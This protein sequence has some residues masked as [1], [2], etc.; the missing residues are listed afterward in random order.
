MS[1]RASPAAR[2]VAFA[3][4]AAFAT[5]HW[6]GLVEP[7][8]GARLAL[9]V[10][11]V[12]A[13][14]MAL[15][16][17]GR[18][19]LGRLASRLLAA[20]CGT[21]TLAL[22]L[23]AIGIGPRLLWPGGWGEL[24]AGLDAG[25]AGLSGDV[26]YPYR[27]GE[28][29]S[30]L[31]ILAVAPAT[32]SAAAMLAFS[33]ALERRRR[34]FDLAALTLLVA[35]Y[36]TA[37][38]VTSPGGALARGAILLVLVGAWLW[39][40]ALRWP[41]ALL[42]TGLIAAAAALAV[43]AA[44]QLRADPWLDYRQWTL[45]AAAGTTYSWGHSYGPID[46][47]RDGTQMLAVR[48]EEAHYWKTVVLDR[49][50]GV[51]WTRG[52]RSSQ[53]VRDI[54]GTAP[55]VIGA[56]LDPR[57][58]KEFT[59]MIADL[60]SEV[61]VAAGTPTRILG[62]GDVARAPDG[63][64]L[65]VG[66]PLRKGD[67]YMVRSYI[68]DPT[69]EQMRAAPRS[70]PSELA[71]YTRIELPSRPSGEAVSAATQ[72]VAAPARGTTL[73]G[74]GM[75]AGPAAKRISRSPYA[76][77]LGL[78]RELT[79]GKPTAYDAVRAVQDHLRNEYEYSEAPPW[80]RYPL[81]AFLTRDRRGY[82]QQFSGTMALMLRMAGIPSRVASGFAP[83]SRSEGDGDFRVED[84]DAHAWVEVYF[85]GIGWV[86][87]DPTPS[88]APVSTQQVPGLPTS[89]V[90]R[91][92]GAP[93][94]AGS[95]ELPTF[96]TPAVGGAGGTT[97]IVPLLAA[98][99]ALL[100]ALLGVAATIAV[101]SRRYRRLSPAHAAEAQLDELARAL[102]HLGWSTSDGT[103]L[104]EVGR[105]LRRSRRRAAAGYVDRVRALRYAGAGGNPPT[106]AERRTLRRDLA[107]GTG[108]RGRLRALAAI[109]PGAPRAPAGWRSRV[110]A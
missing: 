64:T 67:A 98:P 57:W 10:A 19:R 52:D 16:T 72:A 8:P 47:P 60:E 5:A 79:E 6:A 32:L 110:L 104:L 73:S 1:R 82:C 108:A 48:S 78:T 59:V 28:E 55:E 33:P 49:F 29:W 109:P 13:G 15:I 63:T 11:I 97:D 74:R 107:A 53:R 14:G 34:S 26:E 22:A 81:A 7:A 51:R 12:T 80:R 18:S 71:D 25:L 2:L 91:R 89:L 86:A 69:A 39:L 45:R 30:R 95:D 84:F 75:L 99:V 41:D 103:T 70:Y 68:P 94:A 27:E 88:A 85:S 105:T 66:E 36:A 44:A 76:G 56:E 3:A 106:L 4:L 35:L 43:P 96:P 83:G 37:V 93:G 87:F 9:C 102:A 92:P 38:A 65:S 100:V 31:A 23:A 77:M 20:A 101:R 46:W 58:M 62:I 42:A 17:I 61:V 21:A 24:A 50:N 54:S 40:P 90:G